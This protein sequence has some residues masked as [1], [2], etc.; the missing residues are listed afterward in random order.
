[1]TDTLVLWNLLGDTQPHLDA[2]VTLLESLDT[3][4]RHAVQFVYRFWDKADPAAPSGR[5]LCDLL[6]RLGRVLGSRHTNLQLELRW[7][8]DEFRDTLPA[9]DPWPVE[10][11][12]RLTIHVRWYAGGP[13]DGGIP[14]P[15]KVSVLQQLP[16]CNLCL[17][18]SGIVLWPT[19][20]PLRRFVPP[21]QVSEEGRPPGGG[22]RCPTVR[23]LVT[24]ANDNGSADDEVQGLDALY[25]SL[26]TSVK[27]SVRGSVCLIRST[28][29]SARI[30]D[31]VQPTEP[32]WEPRPEIVSRRLPAC[33]HWRT[34]LER[35]MPSLLG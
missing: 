4:P 22:P 11:V 24:F 21:L 3:V 29:P 17:H 2:L 27:P 32:L 18:H 16:G 13:W 25:T 20:V 28:H 26:Q 6:N 12:R 9:I 33:P 23:L 5:R 10:V 19:V 7:P 8:D 15:V 14:N 34:L 31:G 30:P 35:S 1:M